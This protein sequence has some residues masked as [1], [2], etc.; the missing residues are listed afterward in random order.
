MLWEVE[1]RRKER[2]AERERVGQEYN[3]LT[4]TG[5]GSSLVTHTARGY[6]LAGNLQRDQ[7]EPLTRRLL[8]DPLV[9]TCRIR[10]LT[11]HQNGAEGEFVTVL[12]KPG[13]MDP[14]ALSVVNAAADL[15]IAVESVRTF[16]RYFGPVKK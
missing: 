4:H 15:E 9:E 1:I 14:V 12:L 6:L 10:P 13:V 3:L 11:H 2:D 7:V 16:R 8:A 5:L